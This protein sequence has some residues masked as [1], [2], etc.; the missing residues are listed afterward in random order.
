[1]VRPV[2]CVERVAAGFLGSDGVSAARALLALRPVAIRRD[3]VKMNFEMK[4][5]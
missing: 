4:E 2:E 1:M 3:G 5:T